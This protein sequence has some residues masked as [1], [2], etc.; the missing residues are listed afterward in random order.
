MGSFPFQVQKSKEAKMKAAMAGGKSRKKKWA[1]GKART[2][3]QTSD[4]RSNAS[5]VCFFR[6]QWVQNPHWVVF[7][8]ILSSFARSYPLATG[9]PHKRVLAM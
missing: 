4:S 8:F 3:T 9:G 7:F 1:K 6:A 5:E 2:N